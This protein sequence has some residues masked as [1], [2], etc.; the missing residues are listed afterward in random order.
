MRK[1]SKDN[2]V[3]LLYNLAVLFGNFGVHATVNILICSVGA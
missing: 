1:D 3:A 2:S